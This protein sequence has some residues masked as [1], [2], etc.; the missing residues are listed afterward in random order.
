M[1]QGLQ[2]GNRGWTGGIQL[3]ENCAGLEVSARVSVHSSML[4]GGDKLSALFSSLPVAAGVPSRRGAAHPA[5]VPAN[6]DSPDRK[7]ILTLRFGIT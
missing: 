2:E 6:S 5:A 1:V 4:A 3:A 7:P